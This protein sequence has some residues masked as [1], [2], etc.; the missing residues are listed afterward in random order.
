M[1]L[2][3][4]CGGGLGHLT[5][6]RAVAR[7]RGQERETVLL[8]ASPYADDARVTGGM[9]VIRVPEPATAT[10]AGMR[11][12]LRQVVAAERPDEFVVD[13]FPAGL[14]GELAGGIAADIPLTLVAR[15]LRWPAYRHLAPRLPPYATVYAIEE[16]S[17]DYA[18]ALAAAG[19]I[20]QPL[21]LT[22]PAAAPQPPGD[23]WLVV[24][25]G[26]AAE[27]DELFAYAADLARAD[28]LRPELR[29]VSPRRPAGA[30]AAHYCDAYP[31]AALYPA[32]AR[33]ITACGFN[34]LHETLP[35]RE[36]HHFLPLPRRYDD[37]YRR[38]ARHRAMAGSPWGD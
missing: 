22:L 5:R 20:P 13:A 1:I 9:P 36:R 32:A 6:A 35:Y 23:H 19:L 31:A 33:I 7:A 30:A 25:A 4:A 15:D 21:A 12:W 26:P 27:V 38:A 37:Q 8:T 3:Y 11:A 34:A 14:L 24:H 29:V 16:L 10:A 28:G 2:H 18:A 17:E